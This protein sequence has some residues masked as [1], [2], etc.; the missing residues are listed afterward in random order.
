[1]GKHDE[2]IAKYAGK[3]HNKCN[4]TPDMDLVKK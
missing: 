4:M 3:L 1:M 2:S